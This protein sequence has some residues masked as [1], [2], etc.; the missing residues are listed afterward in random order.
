MIFGTNAPDGSALYLES[1]NPSV[2]MH[3]AKLIKEITGRRKESD[4]SFT[5][6]TD[7][8]RLKELCELLEKTYDMERLMTRVMLGTCNARD[9]NA[10]GQTF[11]ILPQIKKILQGFSS[12]L[13]QELNNNLSNLE[14]LHRLISSAIADDPPLTIREGD[15][16]RDGFDSEV[17]EYRTMTKDSERIMCEWEANEKE[18]T[19]IKS[20]KISYNRQK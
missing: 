18:E 5:E 19:G 1:E 20:L 13:L 9:I 7:S 8:E 6:I 16:I 17:D 2:V 10:L 4:I 15:I 12:P 11:G 3:Y 14:D